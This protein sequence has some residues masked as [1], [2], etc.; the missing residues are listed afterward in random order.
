MKIGHIVTEDGPVMALNHEGLFYDLSEITSVDLEYTGNSFYYNIEKNLKNINK[1]V[2]TGKLKPLLSI[3]PQ[4]YLIPI[5]AVNQVRDFYAFEEHVRNARKRRNLDVPPEWYEFPA[6]YYSGN[7]SLFPSDT[8][9]ERPKFTSELDFELEVAAVIGKEG[10]NIPKG[11]AMDYIFGFILVNDWSA[12]DQQR[13]E[14]AI[15][16][17]PSKSKDFATSFGRNIVTADEVSELMDSD[18]KID[19]KVSVEINDREIMTNNINTMHWSFHDLV[20]WAS[21]DVTLRPGDVI[22][23]GTVG[24]GCILELGTDVQ[25]WLQPGDTVTFKSDIFGELRSKI[26]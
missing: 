1:F 6:Y 15:G 2:S 14:M 26:T 21:T 16:L 11:D 20:S 4:S 18:L 13:K 19:A 3:S 5:P 9:I 10:R 25:D 12:R 17:G 7:S 8:D 22:M 23:S 24:K